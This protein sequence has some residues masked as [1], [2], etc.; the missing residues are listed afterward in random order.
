MYLS[1]VKIKNNKKESQLWLSV[2]SDVK[3]K[4]SIRGLRLFI[5]GVRISLFYSYIF[6]ITFT[7]NNNY[8]F[9][10]IKSQ[11]EIFGAFP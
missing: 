4:V 10:A 9:Y 7:F 2:N 5:A 8:I 3:V 1:I 11:Q 6:F